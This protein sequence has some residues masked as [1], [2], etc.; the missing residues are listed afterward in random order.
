MKKV[1]GCMPLKKNVEAPND[2]RWRLTPCPNCGEECWETPFQ[3]N[4]E[5]QNKNQQFVCTECALKSALINK[6]EN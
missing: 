5:Q 2:P 1:Y 4:L 6:E 3:R